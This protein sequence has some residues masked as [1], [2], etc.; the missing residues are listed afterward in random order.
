MQPGPVAWFPASFVDVRLGGAVASFPSYILVPAQSVHGCIP[1]ADSTS[2]EATPASS[3]EQQPPVPVFSIPTA[4]TLIAVDT[5]S[6]S[7]QFKPLDQH[8]PEHS[9]LPT[10]PV[11]YSLETQLVRHS[12]GCLVQGTCTAWLQES[13]ARCTLYRSQIL[14]RVLAAA[15]HLLPS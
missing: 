10:W 7:L 13:K 3:G 11:A 2:L 5:N 15:A 8:N 14:A 4:P 12:A 1:M 9:D 6:L